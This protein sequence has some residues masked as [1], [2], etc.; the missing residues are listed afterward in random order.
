[1]DKISSEKAYSEKTSANKSR[2][3]GVLEERKK[4]E[5]SEISKLKA[6]AQKLEGEI[7]DL[8]RVAM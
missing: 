5:D 7:R 8:E 1:M 2:E 3:L 6:D 4:R